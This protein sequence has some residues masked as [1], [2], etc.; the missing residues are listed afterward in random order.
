M[1]TIQDL[2]EY[3]EINYPKGCEGTL[4]IDCQ[5]NNVSCGT[6]EDRL[7][8]LLAFMAGD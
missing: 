4:C 7:C 6:F 8:T 5:L 1:K 3:I 2:L